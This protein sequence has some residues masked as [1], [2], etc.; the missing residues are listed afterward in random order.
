MKDVVD[1]HCKKKRLL[2]FLVLKLPLT[3]DAYSFVKARLSLH[4][5]SFMKLKNNGR[6]LDLMAHCTE[7]YGN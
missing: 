2:T 5:S 6:I 1:T 4:F 7:D 3:V